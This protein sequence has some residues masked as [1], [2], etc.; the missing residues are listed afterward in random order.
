MIFKTKRLLIKSYD[1]KDADVIY[2]VVSQKEIADTMITIPHPYPRATVNKWIDYLLT[3][4]EQGTAFEFA[5]FLKENPEKY[6]GNCGLVSFSNSHQKAEI[7]YFIDKN[8]WGKGYATEVASFMIG[9]G[10]EKLYLERIYGHCMSRNSASRKVMEK[11]GFR[12]EGTLRHGI[13]KGEVF[14]D[15]DLLGMIRSDYEKNTFA[16]KTSKI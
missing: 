8:E 10:F 15:L 1:H 13:K 9:Y 16:S 6:I 11:I 14:E 3:S 12:F 2:P 4:A 7:A 5:I